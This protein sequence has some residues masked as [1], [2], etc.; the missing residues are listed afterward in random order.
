M[1]A[2]LALRLAFA[3]VGLDR[4]AL[5]HHGFPCVATAVS[6]RCLVRR[7]RAS[8][9]SRASSADL[10]TFSADLGTP[11]LARFLPALVSSLLALPLGLLLRLLVVLAVLFLGPF[12]LLAL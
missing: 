6:G 1:L 10:S 9:A 12:D 7:S 4:E 11:L 8:R 5:V 2:L 3:A